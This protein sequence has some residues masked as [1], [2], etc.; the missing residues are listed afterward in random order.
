MTEEEAKKAL[1][2]VHYEYIMHTPR[3]REE[4]YEEY[5]KK[6]NEIKHELARLYLAKKEAEIEESK[7]TR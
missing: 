4:L 3:E 2:N 1:F 7:K 5:Q 6:R